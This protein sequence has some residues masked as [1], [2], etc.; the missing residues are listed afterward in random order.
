MDHL[1]HTIVL[2]GKLLTETGSSKGVAL[3]VFCHHIGA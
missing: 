1:Y 2:M 3:E